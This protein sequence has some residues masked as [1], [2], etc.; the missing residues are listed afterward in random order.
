[1]MMSKVAW[2]QVQAEWLLRPS[3]DEALRSAHIGASGVSEVHH[4]VS[5][6]LAPVLLPV[7]IRYRSFILADLA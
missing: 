6:S 3:Q 7:L 4:S 1:M 2:V 5:A